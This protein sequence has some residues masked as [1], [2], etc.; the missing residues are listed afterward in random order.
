MTILG[1]NYNKL[2]AEKKTGINVKNINTTPKI[3]NVK[4]SKLNGV[5]SK[6]DVLTIGFEFKTEYTPN[7]GT[8]DITGDIIY[9]SDKIEEINNS[10]EKDKKLPPKT[11][12]EIINHL[13]KNVSIKALNISDMLRMPPVV[14]LPRLEIKKK[15]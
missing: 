3:V 9:T 4:K 1:I 5:G 6:M 7:A 8:I 14:N 15:D 13:F 11:Q 12:I 10:W 2:N